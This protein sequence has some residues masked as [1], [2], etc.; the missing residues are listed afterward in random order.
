MFRSAIAVVVGVAVV[1]LATKFAPGALGFE[2]IVPRVAGDP[3]PEAPSLTSLIFLVL[4]HLALFVA[5][6]AITSVL[7][8][9][10]R[11]MLSAAAVSF[12]GSGL[13][14]AAVVFLPTAPVWA[15]WLEFCCALLGPVAG[16]WLLARND[17]ASDQ[18]N[19][20]DAPKAESSTA[21]TSAVETA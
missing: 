21:T 18:A 5:A 8:Q 12:L 9:N 7:A 16:A 13:G 14:G 10:G 2:V 3:V 19:S 6:G 20:T 11:K 15:H 1:A 17:T 4:L